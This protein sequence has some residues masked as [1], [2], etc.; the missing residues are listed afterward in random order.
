MHMLGLPFYKFVKILLV[1][2]FTVCFNVSSPVGWNVH[3][4]DGFCG[5]IAMTP[6]L[7][8]RMPVLEKHIQILHRQHSTYRFQS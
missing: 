6:S 3:N 8:E 1:A 5:D 2:R 4:S 7:T